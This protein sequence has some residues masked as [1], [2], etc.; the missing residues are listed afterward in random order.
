M[1]TSGS[2]DWTTTR[3]EVIKAAYRL[4]IVDEDFTP[5]TNQ[6]SNASLLL[7]AITKSYNATL[8]MPLWSMGYGFILPSS[9]ASGTIPGTG[10]ITTSVLPYYLASAAS[11]GASTITLDAAP[12]NIDT[13]AIGIAVGDGDVFWTTVSGTPSGA[14]VTLAS[15]LDDDAAAGGFVYVYPVTA[16]LKRVMR[17][18]GSYRFDISSVAAGALTGYTSI[19][20]EVVTTTGFW[21]NTNNFITEGS[22]L[23]LAYEPLVATGSIR[24]WPKFQNS[25]SM[26]FIRYHRA[27]EDFDAGTDTPDFPVEWNLPLIYELAVALAPTY[28]MDIA[29]MSTLRKER[30]KWVSEV[31]DNDYEEG[32]ISFQPAQV[33]SRL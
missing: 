13:Y 29:R 21:E 16:R 18:V 17:I 28:N 15:P 6:T 30:D 24:W 5:T 23:K 1:A 33:L 4:V 7:N 32:S 22:P 26:I 8:G 31:A 11:S 9:A 25:R 3:D 12:G 19:P 20:M 2:I 27:L 14:V 10:H